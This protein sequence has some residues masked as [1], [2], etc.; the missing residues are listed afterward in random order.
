MKFLRG[1]GALFAALFFMSGTTGFAE[2]FGDSGGMKNESDVAVKVTLVYQ[3]GDYESL[4]VAAGAAFDFP[5][6]TALVRIGSSIADPPGPRTRIRVAVLQPD[7]SRE[8][9]KSLE[10]EAVLRKQHGK[11]M[12]AE[13][14]GGETLSGPSKGSLPAS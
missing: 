7:G 10:S 3:S 11:F 9:L 5:E 8:E 4:V 12:K 6:N 14:S 2:P 13:V 1:S